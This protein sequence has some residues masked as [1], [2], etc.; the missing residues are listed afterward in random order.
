MFLP[1][2]TNR[3]RLLNFSV[4][5]PYALAMFL[6]SYRKAYQSISSMAVLSASFTKT[7]YLHFTILINLLYS[8]IDTYSKVLL[9]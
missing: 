6:S 7:V 2:L 9:I 3:M 5:S 4:W 1:V 8:I